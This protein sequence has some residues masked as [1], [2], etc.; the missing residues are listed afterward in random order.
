MEQKI[1]QIEELPQLREKYAAERIVFATGCY[2]IMQSGH[3]V[4]FQQ[5]LEHGDRLVVG[6]GRDSV[7]RTIKGPS[8]P[9]NP[10]YNR[11]YLVAA[12]GMVDY[13]VLNE[14]TLDDGNVDFIGVLNALR[15]DVL[16]LSTEDPNIQAKRRICDRLNIDVALVPRTVPDRLVPTSTSAIIE[17][18]RFAY[19]SPLRIDFAGGWTD[20]PAIMDGL[21]GYVTNIAIA[22]LIE[23][24]EGQF[25]FAGYPRGSGLTTS[26]AAKLLELLGAKHYS[27]DAKGLTEIAEDLFSLENNDLN[28]AIGRQDMYAL[29]FG[30]AHCWECMP[31]TA[32]PCGPVVEPGRLSEFRD[33]L[34]LLHTGISRNAQRVVS[35]VHDRYMT[36]E[37]REALVTLSQLG[38]DFINA[39]ACGAYE[40]C[41]LIMAENWAA[42]KQLAPSCSNDMIESMYAHA[43]DVGAIGGKL[44]GA[45]GGG[46]FV[47]CCNNPD[48]LAIMMK[49]KFPGCFEVDF[50]FES[51]NILQLNQI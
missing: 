15:P 47:F 50:S 38:R 10:E 18:I 41:G 48:E 35:E 32:I 31:E 44:C 43:I 37:G 33:R 11:A 8:R 5:C 13:V 7:L 46:A 3:V 27:L 4:F 22:P 42:Q 49:E 12:M 30:G 51:R 14:P 6:V 40:R 9:I 24:R 23:W 45:G 1:L 36:A 29:V 28:W 39:L 20:V 34:L 19:R 16:V 2:D 26:T 17:K 21:P 25:N